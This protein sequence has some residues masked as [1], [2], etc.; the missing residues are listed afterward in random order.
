MLQHRCAGGLKKKLYLRSGFQRHRHFAGFL[1]V[2]VL[3][4]HGT[5]LFI[6]WFRHTAPF[7]RLLRHAG[8]TEI[9]NTDTFFFNY[10]SHYA[11]IASDKKHA[12]FYLYGLSRTA[13]NVNEYCHVFQWFN[14]CIVKK[15]SH[16]YIDQS[17][18]KYTCYFTEMHDNTTPARWSDACSPY[19]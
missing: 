11:H 12:W 5:T 19:L 10:L 9:N 4:R 8:D 18:K 2:P 13:R 17:A 15:N 16:I 14:I 3:H 7:S 6:R 1:N